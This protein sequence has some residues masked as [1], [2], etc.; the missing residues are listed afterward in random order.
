VHQLAQML[1]TGQ[2]ATLGTKVWRQ[3][4]TDWVELNSLA[5]LAPLFQRP[6]PLTSAMPPPLT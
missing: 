1:A 2:I 3:G 4:L 6:P 5:E